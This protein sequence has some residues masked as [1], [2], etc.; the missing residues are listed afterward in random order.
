[1][2]KLNAKLWKEIQNNIY[3]D[4]HKTHEAMYS[5]IS[6][7]EKD[8]IEKTNKRWREKIESVEPFGAIRCTWCK[9]I[10]EYCECKIRMKDSLS[11][12]LEDKK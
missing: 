4:P 8:A 6:R 7:V 12:L 11:D 1:M 2:N 10:P 9:Q 3:P 5:I